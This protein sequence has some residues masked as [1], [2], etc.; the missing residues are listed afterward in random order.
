MTK[1]REIVGDGDDK[2]RIEYAEICKIIKKN[3]RED[4][5]KYNQEIIREM[6]MASKSLR[7]VR[8]TQKLGQYKL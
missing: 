3:A 6:I 8:R 5:R 4:T 1:Q 2:Q 7:I